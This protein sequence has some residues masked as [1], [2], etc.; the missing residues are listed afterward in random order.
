MHQVM[1]IVEAGIGAVMDVCEKGYCCAAEWWGEFGDRNGGAL[2]AD[3][4]CFEERV[5]KTCGTYADG[6]GEASF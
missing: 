1:H 6:C 4:T 5:T 2:D 3:P